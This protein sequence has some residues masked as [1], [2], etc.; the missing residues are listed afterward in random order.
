M[1]GALY[2]WETAISTDGKKGTGW[3]EPSAE[4]YHDV[5]TTPA[6]AQHD[7][8]VQGICPAT[9]HLPSEYEWA[10]LLD[11]VDTK[12]PS[13]YVDQLGV[14][15]YGSEGLAGSDNEGAGVKLK[16]ALTYMGSDP[17]NGAWSDNDNRGSDA[18]GFGAVPNGRRLR[19]G[20]QF[21][22]RGT[23]FYI[24][25]SSVVSANLARNREITASS[26]NV[27]RYSNSRA[28]GFGVRCVKD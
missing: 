1:Y 12:S 16:S 5:S 27:G 7:P 28:V 20:T 6:A 24:W 4:K 18:T 25:S 9:Y 10:V 15:W 8:Q 17:G 22:S 14:G 19:D 11:A 21:T 13:K 26:P 23:Y 2:T 3:I